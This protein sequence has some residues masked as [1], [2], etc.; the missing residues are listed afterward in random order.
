VI[1]RTVSLKVKRAVDAVLVVVIQDVV[2]TAHN[3]GRAAR[4][5]AGGDYFSE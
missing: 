2:G 3:A 5:E 1:G 4:T